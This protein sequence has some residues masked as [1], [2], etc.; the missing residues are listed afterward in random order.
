MN[1]RAVFPTFYWWLDA[2]RWGWRFTRPFFLVS[3][4]SSLLAYVVMNAQSSRALEREMASIRAQGAPLSLREAAPPPVPDQENAAL[5]YTRA[6]KQ[7]P[8]LE[9]AP[10]GSRPEDG[11]FPHADEAV[12]ERFLAEGTARRKTVTVE[13]V[14]QALAGTEP[15]LAL[16]RQAAAMPRCRFPIDWEAGAG[17]LFP[18]L[19]RLRSLSRLLAAH[20]MLSAQ[21][22][23]PTTAAADIRAVLGITRHITFE[24]ILISQLVGYACFSL[25]QGSLEQVLEATTVSPADL[26]QLAGALAALDFDSAF[27]ESI[28][29]ERCLG[30][31]AFDVVRHDPSRL[32]DLIGDGDEPML[33]V[34][35]HRGP[36]GDPFL[37]MDEI[38]YL[39]TMARQVALAGK[40]GRPSAAERAEAE[41]PFPWYAVVSRLLVPALNRAIDRRDQT[42]ARLA[43]TRSG[44]ALSLYRQQTGHY[45]DS[46][47]ELE[48]KFGGPLPG[49]PFTGKELTYRHLGRGYVL[50]SFGLNA[51]DDGGRN[52]SDKQQTDAGPLD[53]NH[54]THTTAPGSLSRSQDDI[55]WWFGT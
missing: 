49:D 8:R 4:F 19:P 40:R 51:R 26:Q 18:H 7:L 50:Y 17:A 34:Y 20:A 15:A 38:R 6:F 28:K 12:L 45:P 48:Q 52:G 25:A 16:V 53:G 37:K 33:P 43:V 42:D 41:G 1:R 3:A 35:S 10:A 32:K 27:E 9:N 11:F 2:A 39:H 23:D 5:F 30:L 14:H 29:T 24:P 44:L 46:L 54:P 55:A 47:A 22:G 21:E 36:I 31:W 13:Q